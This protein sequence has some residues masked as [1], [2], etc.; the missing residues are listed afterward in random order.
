M[1]FA[2]FYGENTFKI[3]TLTDE[4]DLAKTKKMDGEQSVHVGM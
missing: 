4:K 1:I 3:I 2:N